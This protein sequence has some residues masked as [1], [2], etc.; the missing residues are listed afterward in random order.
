MWLWVL[1]SVASSSFL[2]LCSYCQCSAAYAWYNFEFVYPILWCSIMIVIRISFYHN[3]IFSWL[4]HKLAEQG[5]AR[6]CISLPLPIKHND[7]QTTHTAYGRFCLSVSASSCLNVSQ[8]GIF[9]YIH[10]RVQR[11]TKKNVSKTINSHENA[12]AVDGKRS[13][14]FIFRA[15]MA[16]GGN[17][18]TA[19]RFQ[20]FIKEPC[21]AKSLPANNW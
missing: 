8:K 17:L 4:P 19:K 10:N 9:L 11:N 20:A 5:E 1:F 18:P 2:T 3:I 7:N 21:A 6:N 12:L 16:T 13:F 14:K 15:H